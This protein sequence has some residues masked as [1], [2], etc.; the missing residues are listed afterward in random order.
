MTPNPGDPYASQDSPYADYNFLVELDGSTVAGFRDVS[1]VNMELQTV[2]YQEGGV[3][4]HVHQLPG[5]FAH[6]NVALQRGLSKDTTFW[7]WVQ[8]VMSGELEKRTV[9]VKMKTEF[10]GDS[11]W[12]WEF[13]NAYPVKWS[14]PDL[15]TGQNGMAIETVELAYERFRKISGMP[16]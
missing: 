7:E 2:E 12:G 10:Q 16:E 11:L 13:A 14:G 9:V 3:N 6:A 5:Q 4:D 1:G 15:T 8:T